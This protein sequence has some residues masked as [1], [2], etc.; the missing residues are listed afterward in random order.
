MLPKPKY[1]FLYLVHR[2]LQT[3]QTPPLLHTPTT[4]KQNKTHTQKE[5]KPQETQNRKISSFAY[6]HHLNKSLIMFC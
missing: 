1:F 2:P 6:S 5:Q 3:C 4:P